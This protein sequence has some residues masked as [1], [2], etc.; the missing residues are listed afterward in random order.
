[1]GRRKRAKEEKKPVTY[2][3]LYE[4]G[5]RFYPHYYEVVVPPEEA[6][7]IKEAPPELPKEAEPVAPGLY[8]FKRISILEPSYY[9]LKFIALM[10]G[11]AIY[12]AMDIIVREFIANH[13]DEIKDTLRLSKVRGAGL[14]K[15][16]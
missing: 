11:V 6:L 15:I 7:G 4:V 14:E 8:P 1:M 13:R 9:A 10:R 2:E 3:M 5:R 16:D 12:E